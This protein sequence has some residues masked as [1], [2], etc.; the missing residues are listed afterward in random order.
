[1][2]LKAER[3]AQGHV[4]NNVGAGI[5]KYSLPSDTLSPNS[6]AACHISY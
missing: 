2:L 4:A 1:M 3:L 5:V 6:D